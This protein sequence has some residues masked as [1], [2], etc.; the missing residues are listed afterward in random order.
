MARTF[1][2]LRHRH[3]LLPKVAGEHFSG[4]AAFLYVLLKCGRQ[5]CFTGGSPDLEKHWGWG[6]ISRSSTIKEH[7]A[8]G[9]QEL[10]L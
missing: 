1:L 4:V 6:G 2:P 9:L 7:F 3:S 5:V 8:S 10:G